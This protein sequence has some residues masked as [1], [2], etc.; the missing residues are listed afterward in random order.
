MSLA[1]PPERKNFK[2]DKEFKKAYKDW[3]KAFNYAMRQRRYGKYI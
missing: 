2:T 1:P 3:E